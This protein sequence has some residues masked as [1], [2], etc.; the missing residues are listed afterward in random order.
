MDVQAG[1]CLCCSQT[2]DDRFSHAEA[3]IRYENSLFSE[4]SLF[5]NANVEKNWCHWD[6]LTIL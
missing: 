1:L 4:S 3:Q 6:T 5:I 2:P